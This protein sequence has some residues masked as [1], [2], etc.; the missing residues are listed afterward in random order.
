MLEKAL[1]ALKPPVPTASMGLLLP[2]RFARKQLLEPNV[3]L[4]WLIENTQKLVV[5]FRIERKQSLIQQDIDRVFVGAVQDKIAS[6]FTND[7]GRAVDQITQ[8]RRQTHIDYGVSSLTRLP[9]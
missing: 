5:L 1:A 9:W 4:R 3:G 8:L 2:W 6:S 7:I